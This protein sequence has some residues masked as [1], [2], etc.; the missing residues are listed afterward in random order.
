MSARG[1]V[2]VALGIAWAA[3]GCV[4][5]PAYQRGAFVDP[6]MDP[7]SRALA[8]RSRRQLYTSREAA[9]GGD[10]TSAGGGCACGN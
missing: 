7:A 8:V 2:V 5:V 6:A 3:S 1:V 4:V 10:G 9:A